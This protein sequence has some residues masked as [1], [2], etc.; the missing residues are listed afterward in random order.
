[1]V[2]LKTM[3]V[4]QFVL[5]TI[6]RHWDAT[7]FEYT[8]CRGA[9]RHTLVP[10]TSN[11]L[12]HKYTTIA[13]RELPSHV[14]INVLRK[15]VGTKVLDVLINYSY[16]WVTYSSKRKTTR[17]YLFELCIKTH[18]KWLNKRS[19]AW[20]NEGSCGVAL[21]KHAENGVSFLSTMN[22]SNKKAWRAIAC[23]WLPHVLYPVFH[24]VLINPGVLLKSDSNA[25][26][27]TKLLPFRYA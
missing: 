8:N 23:P 15:M 1:M 24:D 16:K 10:S 19:T 5:R 21:S 3:N 20:W 22:I 2:S 13:C 18:I 4:N 17:S 27:P 7:F 11:P 26:V 25:R 6:N 9:I 14:I 12:C